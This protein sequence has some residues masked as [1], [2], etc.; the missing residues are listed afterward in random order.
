MDLVLT[1]DVGSTN[2]K[3][4]I[5]DAEGKNVEKQVREITLAS[6]GI[7]AGHEPMEL[8][9]SFS[10]MLRY[11]GKK[12]GEK[13]RAISI[14]TYNHSTLLVDNEGT[15]LSRVITHHDRRAAEVEQELLKKVDPYDLYKETGAP[16]IFVFMPYK[17]YWFMKK[18]PKTFQETRYFLFCKDY[19]LWK[20]NLVSEPCIDI[21]T[22]SGGGIVNLKKLRYSERVLNLLGIDEK[23][24][25]KLYEGGM[26]LSPITSK[27]ANEYGFNPN[28]EIILATFDGAAQN[29]SLGLTNK[30]A[31]LNIGTTG[32]IRK[33]SKQIVLDKSLDMRFFTYYAANGFYVVGGASNSSGDSLRWFRDNF[34]QVETMVSSVAGMDAYKILDMEAEKVPAGSEGLIFL[35]FLSGE[36]FPYRDP[37]LVSVFFGISRNCRK[38]H[39]VRAIMEGV[40]YVLRAI[41]DALSENSISLDEVYF[42][43]GGS[44]SKLWAQ[45]LADILNTSINVVEKGEDATNYGAAALA[46]NALRIASIEEFSSRWAKVKE[47]INPVSNNR[48]TYEENY[49]TF[50]KLV[51]I[52]REVKKKTN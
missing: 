19:L 24:L 33:L 50:V 28:T 51:K 1:I 36:R 25:P 9:N 35:P 32:V 29:F 4:L 44:K 20:S 10:F 48:A 26:S 8:L 30:G 23:R 47:I 15:P 39:F 7:F 17:L 37:N 2:M 42:A 34:G 13:I 38:A 5:I 41:Q 27:A 22:A 3:G 43:G 49:A 16:P 14:T 45:I 12:Y 40:G 46:F 11:F 52:V 21:A 6:E 31:I 18:E